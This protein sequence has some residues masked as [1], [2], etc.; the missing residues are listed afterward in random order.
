M[1]VAFQAEEK[2]LSGEVEDVNK[3]KGVRNK[4]CIFIFFVISL[5]HQSRDS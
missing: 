1:W 2:K 5:F 3:Y 4:R